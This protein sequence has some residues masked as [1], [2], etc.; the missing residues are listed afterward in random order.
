MELSQLLE[1]LDPVTRDLVEARLGYR[2]FSPGEEI[3]SYQEDEADLYFLIE[4]EARVK[5]F[6]Q[7]GRVVDYRTLYAGAMF[8]ELA[9]IDGGP[10][11][12]SVIAETPCRT[13]HLPDDVFWE[14]NNT[15]PAFN[16]AVLQH[17]AGMV[18][19]LT[20]RVLEYSTYSGPQRVYLEVL[21]MAM[22]AGIDGNKAVIP[23]P[24]THQ[25]FADRISFHREAVSRQM[26]QLSRLGLVAREGG[27]LVITDVSALK[28]LA[29][30]PPER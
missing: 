30:E 23:G 20:D 3:V 12:A 8:G 2:N 7:S 26:S 4:G 14:L 10:R 11:S 6:S 27:Q 21:R 5:I 18:R 1:G 13:G 15:A 29:E 28:D 24:P 25:A 17:M 16:R 9:L 19:A 22:D